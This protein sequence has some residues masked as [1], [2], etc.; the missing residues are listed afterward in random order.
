MI[1]SLVG[2]DS[3]SSKSSEMVFLSLVVL[4]N[5]HTILPGPT[6]SRLSARRNLHVLCRTLSE[7][8][9]QRERS[10]T[11]ECKGWADTS[12]CNIVF[13]P[14]GAR[15]ASEAH[16]DD[17]RLWYSRSGDEVDSGPVTLIARLWN[18]QTFV[19]GFTNRF[20]SST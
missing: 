7:L 18:S 4:F 9:S 20:G 16:D 10:E 2:A 3:A 14:H 19:S 17:G 11:R 8:K 5:I 15:P 12:T 1:N 6:K 13:S